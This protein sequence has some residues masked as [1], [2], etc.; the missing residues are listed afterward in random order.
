MS[1]PSAL[2]L[3]LVAAVSNGVC[4]AQTPGAAGAL[5]LN[6]SLVTSGVATTDVARRI[7]IAST[8]ADSAVVF[9]LKGTDRNGNAQS[10]TITGVTSTNTVYSVR[11]YATVTGVSSSAGTAGAITVGTNGVASS[12]W[13][14]DDFLAR[15]WF[16]AGCVI[17]P[18]GT[19]YNVEHTYDDPNNQTVPL[20]GGQQWGMEPASANPPNVFI[21]L[22]NQSGNQEF[23][24]A[25]QPIFAHRLTIL[26]G[27]GLVTLQT[28]QATVGSGW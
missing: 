23:N 6:G 27:T 26:S 1:N 16:L 18:S 17:A 8:G 25:N 28:I 14:V 11:D 9:T 4:L 12:V 2:T 21:K 13:V 7:A 3:Q 5:T 20:Y 10:E 19:T 22:N 15:A 24:Y